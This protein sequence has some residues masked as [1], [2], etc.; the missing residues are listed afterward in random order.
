[1]GLPEG[2][3]VHDRRAEPRHWNGGHHRFSAHTTQGL[4]EWHGDAVTQWRD[5]CQDTSSGFIQGEALAAV[6]LS[7]SSCHGDLRPCAAA[8]CR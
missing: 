6:G 1:M 3:T 7:S 8:G 4:V 2:V 5:G